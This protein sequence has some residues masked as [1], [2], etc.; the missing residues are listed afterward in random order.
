MAQEGMEIDQNL[1]IDANDVE[2]AQHAAEDAMHGAD[3]QHMHAGS[4]SEADIEHLIARIS[5]LPVE[6]QQLVA[7][8]LA[9]PLTPA[10]PRASGPLPA[11]QLQPSVSCFFAET[12]LQ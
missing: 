11:Q 4:D 3:E 8:H 9:A 10:S 12:I 7:M 6:Q 5:T 2:G 1:G